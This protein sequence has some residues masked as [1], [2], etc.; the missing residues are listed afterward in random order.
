MSADTGFR[1]QGQELDVFAHARRWKA[2]WASRIRRWIGGDVLEVG[3]GLGE[4]TAFLRNAPVRSWLCL[5]PDSQLA[6]RLAAAVA[7]LDG[8]STRIGTIQSI[9]GRQ[10]DSILYIDVLE[11]IEADRQ[12]LSDAAALLRPGGHIVVLSPARQSLFSAFDAAIGHYR[13]YDR[14]SLRECSPPGCR[15]EAMFYLDCVGMAALLANRLLLRQGTPSVRQIRTWDTFM[16]PVSRVVDPLLR[17]TIG[18]TIVGVWT[19]VA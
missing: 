3:A 18:K 17:Y 16:V 5:E 7:S 11:H 2:Y 4:N 8:C 9:S 15:L 1:Y 6:L 14:N 12:E 19:R 10:F 13:R